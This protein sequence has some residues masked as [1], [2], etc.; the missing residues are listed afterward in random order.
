MKTKVC[1]RCGKRKSLLEFNKA[2]HHSD[3]LTSHCKCCLNLA[4]QNWV[5]NNKD[6]QAKR[7]SKYRKLNPW[8]ATFANIN[9]R[10]TN[11][12]RNC[13]KFYGEKGIKNL[14]KNPKEIKF[15]WFRDKA[16]EMKEPSIDRINPED[17]YCIEN[18]RFIEKRINCGRSGYKGGKPILQFDL[19]GNFLQEWKSVTEAAKAQK[20]S[21]SNL[22]EVARGTQKSACGFMWRYKND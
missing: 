19:N 11:P 8:V 22:S 13:Y 12:N 4:G 14:F 1:T 21:T 18:C 6:K 16:Y 20:S 2:S 17:N 7:V 3:G 5:K 10:C 15:L 9:Q